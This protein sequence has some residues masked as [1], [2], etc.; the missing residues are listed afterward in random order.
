MVGEVVDQASLGLERSRSR[1]PE[2]QQKESKPR[3]RTERKIVRD[4]KEKLCYIAL[5]Y[6][7]ELKST[8]KYG[9]KCDVDTRKTLYVNVVLSSGTTM[10]QEFGERMT[11]E[12]TTLA[13]STMKIKDELPDGNFSTVGAERFRC[14]E[15]LFQPSFIGKEASGSRTLP[16]FSLSLFLSLSFFFFSLSLSLSLT[17]SLSL[18]Q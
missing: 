5:D 14:V 11:N 2:Q 10:F 15:V 3:T 16:S 6:D 7:T 18:R 8:A 9:T 17:L 1:G 12:L 13:T 4:V